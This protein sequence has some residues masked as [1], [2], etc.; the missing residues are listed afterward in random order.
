MFK[1]PE[2][3]EIMNR[4]L[5]T[6]PDTV[7][8]REGSIIWD[9][10]APAALEFQVIYK[11]L[12]GFV[13][14]SYGLTASRE[15]LK[16]RA[17]ERGMLPYQA[18]KSQILIRCNA[19]ALVTIGV[20][21][22]INNI[23]FKVIET[24]EG[25][26]PPSENL[27][28]EQPLYK[29]YILE[30]EEYGTVGNIT[31]GD[32]IQVDWIENLKE[33]QFINLIT[34]AENEEDTEDFR[35]RYFQSFTEQ[36]YGGNITDYTVKALSIP[37]VGGVKVTP[38]H[39]G[40]GTVKLTIISDTYTKASSELIESVKNHFDPE[41]NSGKGLGLAPIGHKVTVNTV[42]EID[43]TI[44]LKIKFNGDVSFEDKKE[45]V[46]NIINDYFLELKDSWINENIII[47]PA[48]II[49]RI[50]V[51]GTNILDVSE[52]KINNEENLA[53]LSLGEYDIPKLIDI[54]EVR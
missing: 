43:V 22:K 34:P 44:K 35:K 8:K 45:Q 21:F 3:K 4:M 25:L 27:E 51:H 10:L 38:V 50:L 1:I 29:D 19:Q 46:K 23:I 14:E 54:V 53:N 13:K 12:L 11:L 40:G 39:L 32:V 6:I 15:Y 30:C 24:V 41:D 48:H 37:G 26:I 2:F 36:A 17:S 7:D 31:Y 18:T 5:S 42:N 9:A 28:E 16:L 20:R 52:V 49:S 47:R 33:I